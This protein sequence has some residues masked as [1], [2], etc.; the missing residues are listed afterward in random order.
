MPKCTVIHGTFEEMSHIDNPN[1]VVC[2][3]G[4]VVMIYGEQEEILEKYLNHLMKNERLE[5]K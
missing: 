2:D 4:V 1:R 5:R 3:D